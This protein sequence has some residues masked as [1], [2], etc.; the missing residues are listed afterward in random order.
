MKATPE[1]LAR[2]RDFPL[3]APLADREGQLALV[4]EI[5]EERLYRAGAEIIRKGEHGDCAFLLV[6]G[7]VEVFDYTVDQEPYTRAIL[8]AD[9][10]PL[11]GE[12]ALVGGGERIATVAARRDSRCWVL[13]REAFIGLGDRH[14]EIGWRLLHQVAQLLAGHLEKTNR[15]VLRLFEALVLEVEQKTIIGR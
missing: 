3:M 6:D 9:L 13:R 14:P 11:F 5:L 1:V 4:A 10:H 15:D 2:L 8:D 12:V 7:E